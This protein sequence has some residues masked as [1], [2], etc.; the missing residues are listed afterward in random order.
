VQRG[1]AS[2][3]N[4]D[5]FGLSVAVGLLI[6]TTGLTSHR[7][8]ELSPLDEGQQTEPGR[9]YRCFVCWSSFLGHRDRLFD[10]QL[11]LEGIGWQIA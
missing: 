8:A 6:A 9:R 11:L 3:L 4:I 2:A 5:N 7:F 1:D 10:C